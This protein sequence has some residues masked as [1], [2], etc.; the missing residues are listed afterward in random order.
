[1]HLKCVINFNIRFY[2]IAQI[3]AQCACGAQEGDDIC[4]CSQVRIPRPQ[5]LSRVIPRTQTRTCTCTQSRAHQFRAIGDRCSCGNAVVEPAVRPPCTCQVGQ[6]S[7]SIQRQPSR[8]NM[9]PLRGGRR[10]M[11]GL[12]GLRGLLGQG[13]RNAPGVEG[14]R[15]NR[16]VLMR[17]Q[18][19]NANAIVQETNNEVG[20]D[21]SIVT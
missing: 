21:D 15:I 1:M 18:Q 11:L 12:F 3:S 6:D 17:P 8:P 9:L 14:L 19:N 13:A 7:N 2:L 10:G 20:T 16:R 4:S 5:Q